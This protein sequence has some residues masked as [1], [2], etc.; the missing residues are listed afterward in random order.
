MEMK[1]K[2]SHTFAQLCVLNFLVGKILIA[3]REGTIGILWTS[4]HVDDLR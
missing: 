1:K 3:L 2:K 4:D